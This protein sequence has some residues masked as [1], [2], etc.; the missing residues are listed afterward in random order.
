M[1]FQTFN[2]HKKKE[3]V[4]KVF[5]NQFENNNFFLKALHK[6]SILHSRRGF[7]FFLYNGNSSS[8]LSLEK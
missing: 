8:S 5:C 1:D 6:N 2:T 3:V 4:K 7:K